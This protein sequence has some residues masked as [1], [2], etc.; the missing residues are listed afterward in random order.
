MN[1]QRTEQEIARISGQLTEANRLFLAEVA[2]RVKES[3]FDGPAARD[4]LLDTARQMLKHQK[5][6]Q[7]FL[8]AY[9]YDPEVYAGELLSDL[10]MRKPR[11]AK[12]KI[13]YYTMIPWLALTWVFFI[14]MVLGFF[15]KW[16]RGGQGEMTVNTTSLLLVAA[17]SILLVVLITRFLGSPDKEKNAGG[18]RTLKTDIKTFV[19]SIGAAVVI[20][21]FYVMLRQMLPSFTVSPWT[22]L[23]LFGIGFI[24]QFYFLRK[25]RKG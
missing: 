5:L 13:K 20:I 25:P 12:A 23:I 6:G 14:Y 16:S 11:T 1:M 7:S 19:L 10:E 8:E 9:S 2:R 15:S 3:E 24:G 21:A 18:Q 4:A 17:G 22:S